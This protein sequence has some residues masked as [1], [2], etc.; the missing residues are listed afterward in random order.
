VLCA[1]WF[2]GAF[3]TD[4]SLFNQADVDSSGAVDLSEWIGV[5]G[6]VAQLQFNTSHALFVVADVD[7][8][9]ILSYNEFSLRVERD[10]YLLQPYYATWRDSWLQ[11]IPTIKWNG[12]NAYALDKPTST[13]GQQ[14]FSSLYW[15][16]TA[17]VKVS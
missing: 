16:F 4:L 5:V 13:F 3:E 9:Y 6:A 8:D 7:Q 11:R 14:Y 10:F 17:L 15:S 1:G 12:P 2:I